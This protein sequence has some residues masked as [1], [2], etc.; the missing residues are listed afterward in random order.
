M[1]CWSFLRFLHTR[2][3]TK[4][5]WG[6]EKKMKMPLCLFPEGDMTGVG[7]GGVGPGEGALQEKTFLN[8]ASPSLYPLSC[9]KK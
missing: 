4:I 7:G 2:Y 8:L 6:K 5:Q 1:K 3:A 9:S